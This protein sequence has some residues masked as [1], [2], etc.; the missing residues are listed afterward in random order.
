MPGLDNISEIAALLHIREKTLNEPSLKAIHDAA[1][2]A[3]IGHNNAH[4]EAAAKPEEVPPTAPPAALSAED[5][6]N[7]N[8]IRRI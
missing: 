4:V 3:L 2:A 5:D 8:G 1:L 7:G 6:S